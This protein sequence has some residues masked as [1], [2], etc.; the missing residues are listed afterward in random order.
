MKMPVPDQRSPD[1][2]ERLDEAVRIRGER[3][4]RWLRNG[5]RSIGQNLA[6]IGSLG[7]TIVTPTLLG[8]SIGRWLDRELG[9]GVFWTFG[10]LVVGL[11]IGCLLAWK[12]MHHE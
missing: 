1:H 11:S 8:V 5:E 3:R 12:R 6:M 10:L 4:E 7:W 2:P 9:W